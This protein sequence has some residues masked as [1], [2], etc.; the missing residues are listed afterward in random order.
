MTVSAIHVI[1]NNPRVSFGKND[2]DKEGH[3][4]L[5]GVVGAAAGLGAGK[6]MPAIELKEINND[7]F[8]KA[9]EQLT[10]SAADDDK[11]AIEAV[12][13]L[14]A[15]TKGRTEELLTSLGIDKEAK[16]VSLVDLIKNNTSEGS[17]YGGTAD[18][19]AQN[20]WNKRPDSESRDYDTFMKER[21]ATIETEL[22]DGKIKLQPQ[23]YTVKLLENDAKYFEGAGEKA[24]TQKAKLAVSVAQTAKEVEANGEKSMMIQ[25]AD[26][27]DIIKKKAAEE[28][29]EGLSPNRD[30]IMKIA[31]KVNASKLY[32]LG[33]IGLVAGALVGHMIKTKVAE[34]GES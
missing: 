5:G 20:D 34:D 1:N 16:E 30:T 33:A 9:Y 4:V 31:D 2:T 17:R 12:K 6:Y 32:I 27:M 18:V 13:D 19:W 11:P 22:K 10:K 3:P 8:T 14:F 28:F 25:V 23:D 26:I 29:E 21:K 24:A 7:T 15:K